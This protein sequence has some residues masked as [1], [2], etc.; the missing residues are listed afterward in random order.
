[1][2]YFAYHL[3]LH[4]ED[5]SG[6]TLALVPGAPERC[7]KIAAAYGTYRELAVHREFKTILAESE[8]GKVLVVSSGIGGPSLSIAVEELARLGIRHFIR[9]GTCGAIQE[10]VG[11]GDL[12]VSEGAVRLDGTS[13]HYAPVSY[14]ACADHALTTYLLRAGRELG[15]RVRLGLTCST[16]SFYPGQERYDTFSGYVIRGLR[17]TFEEWKR[18]GVLN[19]EMEIATLFTVCRVL[20]LKAAAVCGVLVSRIQ[21]ETVDLLIKPEVEMKVS[22]TV[23]LAAKLILR[24]EF[25]NAEE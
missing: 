21:E 11:I 19:Y 14:P 13:D 18:L 5:L 23:A 15:H 7:V 16:A 24:K 22:E 17:N 8:E 20:G 10:D 9:A 1:M 6:V 12:V 3:G 25:R 2:S 4:E